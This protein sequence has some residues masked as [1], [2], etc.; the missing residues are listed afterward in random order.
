[1]FVFHLTIP[2]IRPSTKQSYSTVDHIV[3]WKST[4]KSSTVGLLLDNTGGSQAK[5]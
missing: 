4:A 1:M 5:D 3:R 2:T